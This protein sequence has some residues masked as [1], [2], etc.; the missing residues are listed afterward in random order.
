MIF[1]V[2]VMINIQVVWNVN[3]LVRGNLIAHIGV[4]VLTNEIKDLFLKIIVSIMLLY[5]TKRYHNYYVV[6]IW[7]ILH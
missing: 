5:G 4:G 6:Y 1:W 3:K 2:I 7:C